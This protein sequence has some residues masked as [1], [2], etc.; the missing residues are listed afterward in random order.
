LSTRKRPPKRRRARRRGQPLRVDGA[1]LRKLREDAEL[2]IRALAL[3]VGI[4][5]ST[6]ADLEAGRRDSSQLRVVRSIAAHP[7]INVDYNDLLVDEPRSAVPKTVLAPRSSLDAYV[8]EE[9]RLGAPERIATPYGVLRHFGAIDLVRLF[10]SPSSVEGERFALRGPVHSTRG[11]SVTDG[12]VLGIRHQDG[13]RFELL[14]QIGA[15]EKPMS[16][17][18]MTTNVDDTR[19]LQRAWTMQSIATLVI[20]VM[21]TYEIPGDED[22]VLVTDLAG[23]PAIRRP[24]RRG[25]ELW[26]GFTQI[27]P[28]SATPPKP[29]P[30]GLI[31][32]SILASE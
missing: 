17:T 25:A 14:R 28:K 1:K 2:S 9:R 10:S 7:A 30:W 24:R 4:D 13:S 16:R 29:H 18:V 6:V 23:G 26:R 12:M 32:E 20:R 3:D 5:P 8:D 19:P 22:H 21:T 11:L 31:V 15:I 27:E